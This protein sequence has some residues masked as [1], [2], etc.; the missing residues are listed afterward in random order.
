MPNEENRQNHNG[1]DPND[2][3]KR[4]TVEHRFSEVPRS[5]VPIRRSAERSLRSFP[6]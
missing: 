3:A 2:S 4:V 5:V 6:Q 1:N